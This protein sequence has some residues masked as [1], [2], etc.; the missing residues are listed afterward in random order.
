MNVVLIN[1]PPHHVLEIHDRPEYPHLGLAY[2]AAYLRESGIKNISVIDAKFE[3]VGLA[4]LEKR[5]S[6]QKIDVI[7]I[8]AMTHEVSQAQKIAQMIK[9]ISPST[10]VVFGGAHTTALP[11]QTLEEFAD[12]DIAAFGE[13]EQTLYEL[14]VAIEKGEPFSGINGIGFRADGQIIISQSRPQMTDLNALPLP[15]WDLFPKSPTY[16]IMTARGCPFQCNFCMRVMGSKIRKRSTQN[17]MQEIQANIEEHDARNIHFVDET[18]TINKKFTHE[19]LD[20]MI[21]AGI[22]K[23]IKWVAQSRVDLA[24]YDLFVKFKDAGC[25]W[26]GL[27]VESGNSEILKASRKG[28]TLEQALQAV[29]FAKKAGLKTG[30]YFIIGHPNETRKSIMDTLNFAAKLNTTTV[31][32]GIMVPYPG[33][34]IYDM[35]NSGGGK[36][37]IISPEWDDFNKT[38]GNSL[39]L[40]GLSRKEL[41]KLELLGYF[42]FYLLNFRVLDFLKLFIEQRNL[43]FAVFK[44][45]I[46]KT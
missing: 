12:V 30:S 13:G 8:T 27:G 2:I 4:V 18:F 33:T 44:K 14:I 43:L 41:E 3:G 26:L 24:D 7:G 34:D 35:A 11:R 39:E 10:T 32:F 46:R 21:D 37:K 31:A 40:E 15:A 6:K 1:P 5:L 36:Y 20:M 22:H 25:E 42:K 28:I 16:P 45:L 17:V 23:K 19:L 9:R 38:I 29:K